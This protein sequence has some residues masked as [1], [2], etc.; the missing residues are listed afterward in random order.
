M[1]DETAIRSR[2][3]PGIVIVSELSLDAP[4]LR[5]ALASVPEMTLTVESERIAGVDGSQQLLFWAS[6]GDHERFVEGLAADPTI[7]TH[8]RFLV[9]EDRSLYRVTYSDET[10]TDS[11]YS[12]WSDMD[13][14]LLESTG[15]AR[16]WTVR[17]AFPTRRALER[18]VG[19]FRERGL[20]ISVTT[21]VDYEADTDDRWGLTDAQR[22]TLATAA[23]TGYFD[24]PRGA[25]LADVAAELD[26]SSQA[27]SVRLRRA[28][29]NLTEH[30][31]TDPEVD[32]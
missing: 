5:E 18:F 26:I 16:G 17:F 2:F 11:A 24:V 8:K 21:I 6:G 31:L 25:T 30:A 29:A 20:S 4:V 9:E 15:S 1:A 32:T 12:L 28:Y 3:Q 10:A 14:V 19:W 22:E 23:R 7:E 13:A 27:A